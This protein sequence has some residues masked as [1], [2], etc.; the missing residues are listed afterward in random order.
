M[1]MYQAEVLSKFPVVQHFPFGSLFKW[2]RD[3][4]APAVPPITAA[5]SSNTPKQMRSMHVEN[6]GASV[7][8]LPRRFAATPGRSSPALGA[9]PPARR[10]ETTSLPQPSNSNQDSEVP[11]TKAPWA[12]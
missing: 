4:K 12:R 2:E 10:H 9:T 5:H 8:G 11:M 6:E 1:K 3:P 7:P